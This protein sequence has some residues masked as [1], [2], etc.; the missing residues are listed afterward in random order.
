MN[1]L[2]NSGISIGSF[3]EQLIMN[4]M[5]TPQKARTY[6]SKTPQIEKELEKQLDISET[7]VPDDFVNQILGRKPVKKL[8]QQQVKPQQK[9]VENKQQ[10]ATLLTEEKADKLITLLEEVK[11]LLEMTGTGCCGCNMG[12]QT[13]VAPASGKNKK[14]PDVVL[15][16]S[17]KLKGLKKL[18]K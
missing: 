15:L 3:A 4:E 13:S 9:I 18:R 8:Q 1:S 17:Q 2:K 16:F 7:V 11:S 6:V 12:S 10:P 14:S 5:A